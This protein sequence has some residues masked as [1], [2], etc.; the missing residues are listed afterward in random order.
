LQYFAPIILIGLGAGGSIGLRVVRHI[1]VITHRR[2]QRD[3]LK[4]GAKVGERIGEQHV[5]IGGHSIRFIDLN[6]GDD[7]NLLECECHALAQLI[8]TGQRVNE[9]LAL[10]LKI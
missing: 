7:E 10:H 2:A 8:R 9:E 5:L 3:I 6:I 4:K 1:E